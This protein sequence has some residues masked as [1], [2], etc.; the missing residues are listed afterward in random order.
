MKSL[1]SYLTEGGLIRRGMKISTKKYELTNDTKKVS[2]HT[3]YQIQALIDFKTINGEQVKAG[4]LGGWIESENNLSQEGSCWVANRAKVF[5]DA[6][7]RDNAIVTNDATIFG[8]AQIYDKAQVG[9]RAWICNY[10]QVYGD[11]WIYDEAWICGNAEVTGD[12]KVYGHA[13]VH[14]DAWIYG[15]AWI[16]GSAQV[17]GSARVDYSVSKGKITK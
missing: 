3:L 1:N 15:D 2:G 13:R 7:V 17:Y 10:A 4:D 14:G 9:D 11:A 16:C 6:Q 5:E 12:A 8:R